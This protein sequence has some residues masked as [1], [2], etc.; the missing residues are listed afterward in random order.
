MTPSEHP[1][2]SADR[3][4]GMIEP[5]GKPDSVCLESFVKTDYERCH[6]GQTFEDLKRRTRFTADDKGLLREWM[7]LTLQR[8]AKADAVEKA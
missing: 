8:A 6:P 4:S 3:S 1:H 7:T 2:L 5:A